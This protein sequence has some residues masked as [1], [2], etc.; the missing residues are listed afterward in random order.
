MDKNNL[1]LFLGQSWLKPHDW[2][3][4][5]GITNFKRAGGRLKKTNEPQG[6]KT[7]NPRKTG[8]KKLPQNPKTPNQ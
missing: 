1:E 5:A 8:S 6:R 3:I 4:G 2:Q 7:Y